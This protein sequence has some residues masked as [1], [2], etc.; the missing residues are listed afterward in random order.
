[1]ESKRTERL[2]IISNNV[3][4]NT[5]NNGKTIFSYIDSLERENVAQLYFNGEYPS[6]GGYR[7]YQIT[8]K[9]IIKGFFNHNKRGRA[10][11][12]AKKPS[13]DT[14]IVASNPKL[15]KNVFRF[16]RELLWKNKWKSNKLFAFLDD[17]APTA[18]FFVGGDTCKEVGISQSSAGDHHAV[19]SRNRKD[20]LIAFKT[21]NVTVGN[22]G[23]GNRL[24]H[25]RD[26]LPVRF[27][28]VMLI[29]IPS[30]QSDKI[31]PCRLT[32]FGGLHGNEV[33]LLYPQ[34]HFDADGQPC[35][36]ANGLNH[37]FDLLQVL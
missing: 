28:A 11:F 1:M 20:L 37:T 13:A 18:V 10:I 25:Q 3:L 9:D 2:L 24:L 32:A 30:V 36:A 17:F 35:G 8:D 29:A 31:S 6:I 7:Y 26:L 22:K 21:A 33:I 27:A 12:D 34:S 19:G 14:P 5:R 23:D 15:K 4:S 16:F